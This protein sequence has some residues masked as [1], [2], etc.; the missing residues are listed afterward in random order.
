MHLFSKKAKIRANCSFCGKSHEEVARLISGPNGIYICNA[1]TT[2]CSDIMT[3]EIEASRL[4]KLG[5]GLYN[6][7][8]LVALTEV[9][10]IQPMSTEW[11]TKPPEKEL[12]VQFSGGVSVRV[13]LA[14]RKGIEKLMLRG[15]PTI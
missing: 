11:D 5:D 3:R 15:K 14:E 10:S 4:V 8:H 12:Y 2:L 6:I 9:D 13:P 1:C 7:D